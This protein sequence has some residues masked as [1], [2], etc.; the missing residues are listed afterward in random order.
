MTAITRL[1]ERVVPV[2]VSGSEHRSDRDTELPPLFPEE[3]VLLV[4]G[5]SRRRRDITI[6]R[7]CARRALAVLGVAPTAILADARG[8]PQWPPRVVG[9]IT[10]TR[11][12]AAAIVGWQHDWRGL[13][14]DAE[15]L[16]R[17]HA[18]LEGLIAT[19]DE[20]RWLDAHPSPV[21]TRMRT[22]LFSAKEAVYKCQFPITNDMLEFEDLE[23]VIESKSV[24]H[25][26]F[27]VRFRRGTTR[28]PT[29]VGRYVFGADHVI[30]V[31]AIANDRGHSRED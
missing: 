26:D 7:A 2:G 18:G 19:P 21:R 24:G 6:G 9:S 14:I 11:D 8:V 16:T 13:G 22:L 29:I 28:L 12:Y 3:A 30:T 20:V 27:S 31:A 15:E 17:V 10:H 4:D 25:G 23:L 1:L 5:A